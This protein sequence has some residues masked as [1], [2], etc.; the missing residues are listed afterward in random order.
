[1]E[2]KLQISLARAYVVIDRGG[3]IRQVVTGTDP[4]ASIAYR[5]KPILATLL[6]SNSGT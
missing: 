2:S 6:E 4:R 5:L 1:M 3:V